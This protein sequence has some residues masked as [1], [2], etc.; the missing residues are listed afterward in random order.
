MP[1]KKIDALCIHQLFEVQVERTPN[2]IAVIFEN[3]QL[4]YRALNARANQ[5]A[6]YL[7]ELGV[8]PDVLVGLYLE[9]SLDMT[10]GLLGILKA[11]GA[12]VPLDPANP[13]ERLA[14]MLSDTQ[15]PVLLTQKVLMDGLPEH[16]AHTVC[17]DLDWGAISQKCDENPISQTTSDNLAYVIYTSGSTGKPKG[18]MIPHRAIYN[19]TIWMQKQFPLTEVDKVLQKTPFT[20]DAS[21]WE[22]FTPLS[23]GAQLFMAKPGGQQDSAYLVKII[24]EQ[25]ITILQTVPTL[26]QML[27]DEENIETCHTLK[28]LFCGG[29]ILSVELKK[30]VFAKLD[31]ELINLYG[32]TEAC[33]DTTFFLC[34]PNDSQKNV[35]IGKPIDNAQIYILD[36]NLQPVSDNSTGE[37]YI[38]GT[39]L[40]RGYLNR[41]E[42][43]A[44]KF[45]PNPFSDTSESRLYKTGDLACYLSDDNIEFLGR[46]DDQVK[47]R[48]FRIELSEIEA[49]LN[50]HPQV[51]EAVVTAPEIAPGDKR[52]VAY[53][54]DEKLSNTSALRHFL[55]DKLPDYMIPAA[56]KR[57]DK[58]PLTSSGK[59]DRKALPLPTWEGSKS[60][61]GLPSTPTEIN[62]HKWWSDVFKISQLSIHDNFFEL[63]GHSLLA[64][65]IISRVRET[66][67]TDIPISVLFDKPTVVT[68]AAHIDSL[69]PHKSLESITAPIGT[70]SEALSAVQTAPLSITQQSFWLFEQLHPNTPTFNIPFA[71]KLTGILNFSALEQALSE[72]VCRHTTLRTHFEV[73]ETGTPQ[74]R[75]ISPAPYSVTVIDL[76]SKKSETKT[77]QVINEE[78]RRPFDL[79][80]ACLW[81]VTVL[82]LD[83]QEQILLL[84]FHHLITDGWSI[85]LF[86]QELIELYAA[87]SKNATQSVAAGIPKQS[88]GTR[89]EWSLETRQKTKNY[90]YTDFCR[91][92]EEWLQNSQYQSQLAYWQSQLKGPLPILELPTDFPRPPVQTYQ[93]ARQP[94]IL[95]PS[96]TTALNNFSHQQS[97]TLF[98]TLLAAFKTLLYRYTGQT[99]LSLGTAAAGRQGV[100][101]ENVM[102]LFINNLVLRTTVSGQM[103]FVSFLS[104]VREVALAAYNHQYLPFQNLIDSLH[105]ERDLSH[106]PLFQTFF[107]LQNFDSPSLNL[108]GL[109]TTPLNINTGTVKFDLT[110]ELYEKAE[111]ITGW[112]EYNTALFSAATMQRMLGHFQ[113]LLESIVAA[114][115][116]SLST[117][118]I[119][120]A[121]ERHFVER[122]DALI[123]PTN[124]FTEFAKADIEQSISERFEQQVRKYPDH[125]AVQTKDEA[126]TYFSLNERANQVAQTLLKKCE[127]GNI[128]LLFEHE[129]SMIV[130]IFGVLKAGLTYIPLA[131]DLPPQRLTYILQ[132]SQ[133][134]VL[135]TNNLN[136]KLAQELR[137]DVLAVINIDKP[138]PQPEKIFQ[139]EVI[140]PDTL[141]YILYTSGSTGQPKGVMQNHRNVLHFIRNYTNNLHINAADKLTL[142]SAY[143]F[144][145]AVMDIFGALLNGATLYPINIKEDSLANPVK[146]FIKEQ[147]ITIYHST[148]TVY[149]HVIGTLTKGDHFPKL[150]LIV[151]GGEE[152]SK[153][154]VDLYKQHFADDCIFINGLGPTES[155]VSLQYFIN[156]HTSNPQATVPV[157]YPVADTEILLLNEA[158]EETEL[159]GEIGLKSAYVAL[160]YWQKPEITQ[161]AFWRDGNRRLYRMGDM[162]RLRVDGSLEFAGRK[163]AQIKLRGYRI[164]LGEIETILDQ[165]PAVQESLVIVWEDSSDL[166]R[167]VAYVVTFSHQE[168]LGEELR[169]FLKDKLPDYMVPSAFITIDKIPLLPNGKVDRHQLPAPDI[170]PANYHA[171]RNALELQLT[172]IWEKVLGIKSIG[173]HDNF[174][175]LGGHSLLAVNLLSRIE[176]HLDKHLPLITLFQ[177]PTIGQLAAILKGE[178]VASGRMLVVIQP[179][180]IRPPFF[181][182]GSTN[183]ARALAPVLGNNQPV[184]GL[185]I[186]GL[187][188]SDGTIPSLD[189]KS[190]AKQYCQE[191]RTVQAEGPYYLGGYC[192]DAKIAF[193]IAQQLQA[194]GYTVAFLAF[195]DVVWQPQK[196]HFNIQR[197]WRNFLE[198]GF[199]R[200]SSFL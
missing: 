124:A 45:I 27:L 17:L 150:R 105:P 139:K 77:P 143:S 69:V 178:G 75:I 192:G 35:S 129:I 121:A 54:I 174:F 158:G 96:F 156:K 160:G 108:N 181:F 92:Q 171:P 185:N 106:N 111:G 16:H 134:R 149:R 103:P 44:E 93:G 58:M 57:L 182:I 187:Q 32:P 82:R 110:L 102:G 36:Q 61:D 30:R 20:F 79:G 159:Y 87:F 146:E 5:L 117:L 191:I 24:A 167:L 189:V 162:G 85:G 10:V 112:F 66:F 99:D 136:W 52:L 195:I 166:K 49:V 163:D 168:E 132:D 101:W 3:Q 26:L 62:L 142:F 170:K 114:P 147:G 55:R 21:V 133:A 40:A 172:K 126:L 12:Y 100:K 31:V 122:S 104:Q 6:Y 151:L 46:T 184:Y 18:V 80:Q 2:A 84:I 176:K 41:P 51:R 65:R 8:K 164:E 43:T 81:R 131:P 145:A 169:R 63:G 175:D 109:T 59:I 33:V 71:F 78:I 7:K 113:T 152:A 73:T 120:T 128:A 161:A 48:G 68:L 155:T 23:V 95:S 88:L 90:Q 188:P 64:T 157:G 25:K 119:L 11:G 186:F 193:E 29:E 9:R 165:H 72:M 86:I 123:C 137:S 98:M 97:V 39:G 177:A 148:P 89:T 130:G 116:T 200:L 38:G 154:D 127:N 74:Q 194:D 42:L 183:Y 76:R 190:I 91:W 50:Q 141:A 37:M 125:I 199:T 56:F 140:P 14:F 94:I 13:K 138:N 180:G 67:Q 83:E 22:F 144:D 153:T 1:F 107:L 135:L 4:T 15:L 60:V 196:R 19:H 198:M 197:H 28:Y 115:E 47:I 173:I 53:F 179:Q 118:R 34:Q 70:Q